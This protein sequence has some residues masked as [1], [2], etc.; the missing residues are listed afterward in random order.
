MAGKRTI[1]KVNRAFTL[2]EL[3]VVIAIIGLVTA[4]ALPAVQSARESSR[5]TYCNNHI[6]QIAL[7][8][9]RYES[10]YRHFPSGGWGKDWLGSAGRAG[11]EQPG[12]WIYS[13]LPFV[14]EQPVFDSIAGSAS[15]VPSG[16]DVLCKTPVELF[17][18]PTRRARTTLPLDSAKQGD[19]LTEFLGDRSGG[20]FHAVGD[21]ATR[22]DYCLNG[23]SAARGC[24]VND[25]AK[26]MPAALHAQSVTICSGG[27]D[28]SVTVANLLPGGMY[29]NNARLGS[30][31]SGGQSVVAA[32][33]NDFPE[34]EGW[35]RLSAQAVASATFS[36]DYGVPSFG[37]GIAHRMSKVSSGSVLDGLS[38]VYLIGEKY[39]NS[40]D[41][42]SGNDPGD[43]RPMMVGFSSST[44]RWA[45]TVPQADGPEDQPV[46]FGS[47]HAGVWNAAFG[48][49]SVRSMNFDID[50]ETHR[51]LA[52]RS[53]RYPGELLDGF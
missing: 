44:I 49:G 45:R 9:I 18:C 3:L 38:N 30:C 29:D 46:I 37:N 1:F 12:G 36:L 35:S 13:V 22:S 8:I 5:R 2:I 26:A 15:G 19:Y 39:V 43:D 51:N 25:Y 53:P 24:G 50:L 10:Q 7:G 31:N 48:D 47:A 41:Y 21:T 52:A 4:L 17:A 11:G 23:G 16:Y 14:E 32:S 33:P 42:E 28:L 27:A 40:N 20:V 34:G 6:R